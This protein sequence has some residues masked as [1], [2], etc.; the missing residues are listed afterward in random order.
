MINFS[1]LLIMKDDTILAENEIFYKDI[2]GDFYRKNT[3][4]CNYN[5]LIY[6][7]SG[8]ATIEI[9]YRKYNVTPNSAL[10]LMYM[11]ILSCVYHTSDFKAKAIFFHPSLVASELRGYDF[12]FLSTLKRNPLIV[13]SGKRLTFV[14]QLFEIVANA[15]ELGSDEL[16]KKTA[17]SQ[18]FCYVNMLKCHFQENDMLKEDVEMS[19]SSK[20]DYFAAFVKELFNSYRRSRE[21]LFYANCLEISSNYLNE[22]CQSVCEHS[23]KEVIDHYISS[24]LKFELYKTDK[25]MS[26]L[27]EEYNFPNQ[28]YLSRYYRRVMGESPTDTRKNRSEKKL[29]IF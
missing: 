27:A 22:V 21:V 7:E 18:C 14:R 13:W 23:A 17:V 26:Q 11:D 1:N 20:K 12:L 19:M 16:F 8:C 10:M 6:C 15:N 24:Q 2:S 29:L 25:S 5:L 4:K 28:S 9:N 3:I